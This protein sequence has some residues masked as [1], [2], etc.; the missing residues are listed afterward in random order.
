MKKLLLIVVLLSVLAFAGCKAKVEDEYAQGVTDTTVLVG[1]TAAT[2]GYFAMVGGPFNDGLEA[3]FKHYNDL[4]GVNGRTITLKHYDD[5]FSGTEGY[6]YT[7][8]LIEDDKVFALV[9][10]FGTPT[11]GGTLELIREKGI[12]MVY[13]ATGIADLFRE[14][15]V[16]NERVVFPVQ[17]IYQTEGRWMVAKAK[18]LVTG[19]K[20]IGVFYTDDE[21]GQNLL[22][23]VEDRATALGIT[24]V[25]QQTALSSGAI[26]PAAQV[27]SMKD[28]NVDLI[29]AAMNQ[30][31]FLQLAAELAKQNSTKPVVTSYVSS[32]I[33][34]TTALKGPEGS[35]GNK[36]DVYAGAWVDIAG[37]NAANFEQFMADMAAFGKPELAANAFAMAGWI[38]GYFFVEGL[39]RV[40]GVVTWDKFVTAMESKPFENPLGGTIDFAKGNR[41]GTTEMA[42]LKMNPASASGLGWDVAIGLSGIK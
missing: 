30:A 3:Y 22:K 10:H 20:K 5:G 40:K 4:G 18:E 13:A 9:G 8:Q 27:T 6:A 41:Y 16:G 24:L 11:V 38:A 12:P 1:N 34:V 23:G 32:N 19:L 31:P 21:A 33:S 15:A 36:F 37:D 7:E 14:P 29:I 35:V 25:K 28:A 42:M 2:S 39:S 17:P 26:T